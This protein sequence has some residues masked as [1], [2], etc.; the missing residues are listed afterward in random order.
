MGVPGMTV[1]STT[2]QLEPSFVRKIGSSP[3][4]LSNRFATCSAETVQPSPGWWQVEQLRPLVPRLWK[5][6]PVRSTWPVA[7]KVLRT[8]MALGKGKRFG[9]NCGGAAATPPATN[10][11]ALNSHIRVL[12]M[13]NLHFNSGGN[14][15]DQR[16]EV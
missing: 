4:E 8:P 11:R 2:S 6:G 1:P 12:Y 7:L 15:S 13:T 3:A 5:N 9:R 10:T 14:W 16:V